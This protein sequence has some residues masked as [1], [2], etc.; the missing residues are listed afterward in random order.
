MR[1]RKAA[2]LRA[3]SWLALTWVGLSVCVHAQPAPG[4][5]PQPAQGDATQAARAHFERGE[6]AYKRGDYALAVQEW[7][8][9][10]AADPRPRIQYNIYQ[11]RERLGEL[12]AA[13]DALQRYLDAAD[14]SDPFYDSA[15]DRMAS[16]QSRLQATGVRLI[17]GPPGAMVRIDER[18]VG[19]LPLDALSLE[20]GQHRIVVSLSGYSDFVANVVAPAGQTVEVPIALEAIPKPPEPEPAPPAAQPAPP[21]RAPELELDERV[22]SQAEL[23]AKPF[24]LLSAG[25]AGGSLLSGIWAL[26]RDAVLE[27]CGD[28][29]FFCSREGTVR[30]QRTIAA[31]TSV[32]LGTAAVSLFVYGLV[33]RLSTEEPETDTAWSCRP[34]VAG[35][36]CQLRF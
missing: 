5:A 18:E 26:N 27:G 12:S 17:G 14:R 29:A 11:A 2:V 30:S 19:P 21:Q 36:A 31:I 25:L 3:S 20:P 10:Y 32:T 16:L 7:E 28:P 4:D 24:L 8:A 9:A 6:A 22:P 13:A 15:Q 34:S 33:L 1:V 35:A 23:A